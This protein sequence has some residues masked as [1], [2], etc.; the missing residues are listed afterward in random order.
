M[1][2]GLKVIKGSASLILLKFIQRGLGLISTLVLA[3]IL[4]PQD[5]GVVAIATLVA[6]FFDA[7]SESGLKEYIIHKK[8]I[9]NED[10]CTAWT[11]NMLIKLAIWLV[12]ILAVPF[13]TDYYDKPSLTY[14]LYVVSLILPLRALS[15]PGMHLF[16]KELNYKPIIKLIFIEKIFSIT[17]TISLVFILRSYWAMVAGI[18][19]SQTFITIGGYYFHELRPNLSIKNIKQQWDF[20]K[21]MLPKGVFGYLRAEVDT[22][23]VSSLF[24]LSQMGAYNMM[25]NL[26]SM[27]GRDIIAPAVEPIMSSFSK[28]RD[29]AE[30]IRFQLNISFWIL[31]FATIPIVFFIYVNHNLIIY[32]L[33][34]EQWEQHSGIFQ[35]FS[36]LIVSYAVLG[37][38]SSLLMAFGKVKAHFFFD[39]ASFI[40][41]VF[42]ML[43]LQLPD[44]E[45]YAFLRSVLALVFLIAL[46][47]YVRRMTN[48]VISDLLVLLVPVITA[49]I[50]ATYISSLDMLQLSSN[51]YITFFIKGLTFVTSYLS[52]CYLQCIFLKDKQELIY[53]RWMISEVLRTR[54]I[55]QKV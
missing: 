36:L 47:Y 26:T 7:I 40:L 37:N 43:M 41:F 18:I 12:F 55:R 27:V 5:Y 13:I 2:L 25:K 20:M 35:A 33:L 9:S 1:S 14:V 22:I 34:G 15:N 11:L 29:E 21:W 42:F 39:V 45:D 17:F 54:K 4:T 53:I 38:L 31:L 24:S 28:S 23:I 51:L 52:L 32:V 6:W 44:I 30:K 46:T 19:F 8:E 50:A 49:A 48:F 16:D 3:R 10:V